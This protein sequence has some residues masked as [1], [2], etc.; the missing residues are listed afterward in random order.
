[1]NNEIRHCSFTLSIP[2]S[3]QRKNTGSYMRSHQFGERQYASFVDVCKN[4]NS[5][6]EDEIKAT[7]KALNRK[8]IKFGAT[9]E[10][11][12]VIQ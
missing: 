2:S 3:L 4:V 7:L 5:A 1:M 10:N 11:P 6:T 12:G 8:L 9:D